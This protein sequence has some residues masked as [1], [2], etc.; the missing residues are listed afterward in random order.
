METGQNQPITYFVND[1]PEEV[2]VHQLKVGEILSLAAMKPEDGWKLRSL[3][4]Y[5]E[6]YGDD[7][8]RVVELHEAQRFE[9]RRKGPTPTS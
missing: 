9:A 8:E 5:R 2:M 1:E 3:E 7:Y 6:D 4:P